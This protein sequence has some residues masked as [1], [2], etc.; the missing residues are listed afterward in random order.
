MLLLVPPSSNSL[1]EV[2]EG[3]FPDDWQGDLLLGWWTGGEIRRLRLS[4][5]GQ[6]VEGQEIV[7]EGLGAPIAMATDP[8]TGIIY[9]A[10]FGSGVITYLAP[11]G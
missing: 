8:S 7:L 5:D 9:I 1:L 2:T 11:T 4:G 3:V 10:E 6:T